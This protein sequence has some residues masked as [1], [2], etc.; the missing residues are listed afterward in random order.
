MQ[1]AGCETGSFAFPMKVRWTHLKVVD[2]LHVTPRVLSH[3]CHLTVEQARNPAI[4]R[5]PRLRLVKSDLGLAFI[6][7]TQFSRGGSPAQTG[8]SCPGLWRSRIMSIHY[9]CMLGR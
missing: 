6:C 4:H 7:L 1:L 9:G 3:C 8:T 5:I 2:Q